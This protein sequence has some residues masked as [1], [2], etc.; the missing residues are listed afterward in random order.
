[1]L[2]FGEEA[3]LAIGLQA[4]SLRQMPHA[5]WPRTDNRDGI[6][7]VTMIGVEI[8]ARYVGFMALNTYFTSTLVYPLTHTPKTIR[9]PLQRAT[10]AADLGR[11]LFLFREPLPSRV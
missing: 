2:E 5:V 1:M 3:G 7:N 4:E 10:I 11:F 9:V 6:Q 8:L